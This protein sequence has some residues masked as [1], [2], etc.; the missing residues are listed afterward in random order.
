MGASG[1]DEVDRFDGKM[2]AP[3]S[4]PDFVRK[5]HHLFGPEPTLSRQWG[6]WFHSQGSER[7]SPENMKSPC[8]QSA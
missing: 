6:C 2:G 7:E 5:V 4:E 3:R 8:V 1:L